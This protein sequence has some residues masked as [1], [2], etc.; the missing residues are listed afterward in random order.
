MPDTTTRPIAVGDKVKLK[1]VQE[2]AYRPQ[3]LL[4][5]L[6]DKGLDESTAVFTV[7]D[8]FPGPRDT[9]VD[10]C[11][12]YTRG[13]Y[14]LRR[15][16]LV[17]DVTDAHRADIAAIGA[18]LLQE[19]SDRGWCG[20]FDSAIEELNRTLRVGLPGRARNYTVS[21]GGLGVFD[22][23][24]SSQSDADSKAA[25]AAEAAIRALG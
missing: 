20:A 23:T 15:F 8:I 2:S 16:E 3:S 21:I 18:R 14:Y 13:G 1:A 9:M 6:T 19:A 24:A 12:L 17:P 25:K 10:F 22:V 7:S 5:Y 11:E 4:D